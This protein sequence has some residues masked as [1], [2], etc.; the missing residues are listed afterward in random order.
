MILIA[1]AGGTKTDWRLL[2]GEKVTALSSN[3]FNPNTHDL[4]KYM[5]SVMPMFTDVKMQVQKIYFYGASLYP[6]STDFIE[7][8]NRNFPEA[9]VNVNNDLFGSCRALSADQPG[10]VGI[11]GTGSAGCFYDGEKVAIHPPSL[12][13]AL[14]DEGSGAVLGKTLLRQI[15]RNRLSQEIVNLFQA[16]Y[17]LRKEEL[18]AEVYRGNHPNMYL[19]SFT[20]F[21]KDQI[22]FPEINELVFDGFDQYFEAFF[23]EMPGLNDHSFHFTGSVAFHFSDVL[24]E[25]ADKRSL[26]FGNILKSPIEGLVTYHQQHG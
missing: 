11:M 14:G 5:T 26:R 1:D 8:M 22:H 25:V 17:N 13:Y 23:S 4:D 16:T 15:F 10:F 3:G 2:D 6:T 21:L 7:E 18:Y 9:Q 20:R 12:G 24:K 19:A